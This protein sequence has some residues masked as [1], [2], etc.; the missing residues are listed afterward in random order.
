VTRL[1]VNAAAAAAF[2]LTALTYFVTGRTELK[3]A[4][5]GKFVDVG[6]DRLHYIEYGTPGKP[7]IVFVHGLC[8]QLRNFAY[9]DMRALAKDYHVVLV[10]R[11]GAG[12]SIRGEGSRANVYAQARTI[13]QFI[14]KLGLDRPVVFGHSLGG[15]ITLALG[16]NHAQQVRRLGLIAPLTMYENTA[17]GPFKAL[18]LRWEPLR[19]LIS[20]TGAVPAALL[21]NH[22]AVKG[23]FHPERVPFDFG[24]KGGGDSGLRS[25][26]FYAASSDMV[27]A[28]DDLPDMEM[29]Y[30]T[31]PVPV[32]MLFGREDAIL[33]YDKHALGLQKRLPSV[34][35]RTVAG[36]H[37]LPVTQPDDTLAWVREVAAAAFAEQSAVV[38]A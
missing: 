5:E 11:P 33:P 37:M 21:I 4:P 23:V 27:A 6:A 13:A 22:Q 15:A 14:A 19:R 2:P 24:T 17:P 36:G 16:L 31:M 20:L 28:P 18:R 9:M 32:D 1:I 12:Q 8:G 35:L 26:T 34:N 7:A 29:R 10:D 38:A 25:H 30:A 3:F